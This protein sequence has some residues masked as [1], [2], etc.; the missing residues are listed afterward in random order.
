VEHHLGVAQDHQDDFRAHRD[1]RHQDH[2]GDQGRRGVRWAYPASDHPHLVADADRLADQER[3]KESL[4]L[5]ALRA[6]EA[7]RLDQ[8]SQDRQ[9]G[10]VEGLEKQ[11]E[12]QLVPQG[13]SFAALAVAEA[14]PVSRDVS[15]GLEHPAHSLGV[16]AA[17]AAVQPHPELDAVEQLALRAAM[18]Q[19]DDQENVVESSAGQAWQVRPDALQASQAVPTAPAEEP[20]PGP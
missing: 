10:Q 15:D 17:V 5:E 16:W 13:A 6:P 4:G 11:G 14:H 1:D 2:Q 7:H 12:H 20:E 8:H 18:V 19:P 9:V 3:L